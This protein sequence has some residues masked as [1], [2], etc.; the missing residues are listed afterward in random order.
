MGLALSGGTLKAAA[1]VGVLDALEAMRVQIDCVAG[2]S[3]GSYV[4]ALYAHGLKPREM[5]KM[6]KSFPG[7]RL[8]DYGFPLVSSLFTLTK[9]RLWP[10]GL[11]SCVLPSGLLQGRRLEEYFRKALKKR[12]AQ[13]PY[14]LIATDLY[15]GAPVVYGDART[16]GKARPSL[17]HS[18]L[19]RQIHRVTDL[20]RV[21]RGSCS[22]PGILTPVPMG[23]KLLVDG[24][25][26]SYVPVEVLRDAGCTHI[27]AVNLYRLQ[28]KWQP[29]TFAHVLA[30][31]F[32]IILDE[33]IDG[34]V[35]GSDVFSL[36]PNVS[37]ISWHSFRDM[38]NC[39]H[40]G[41]KA[42]TDCQEALER[43][44][45]SPSHEVSATSQ[46][47]KTTELKR[48]KDEQPSPVLNLRVGKV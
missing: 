25:L 12:S 32:D 27:I 3:A 24:G 34:D 13:L 31:S 29:E 48:T 38:E 14:Y 23:E 39:V 21:V 1:H 33:T 41:V 18:S 30:R 19:S 5:V 36:T 40:A 7:P 42:V 26:R 47:N 20:A 35:Q 8:L 15:S 10:R 2:T 17:H 11:K 22:L 6:V 28:E 16:T 4:A 45:D 44:L 37:H 46:R 9:Y 43:F